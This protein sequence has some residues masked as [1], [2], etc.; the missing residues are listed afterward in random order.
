ME[1]PNS[2]KEANVQREVYLGGESNKAFA[3]LK[4]YLGSPQLL[5]R[6]ESGET[7]QLYLAISDVAVSSMLIKESSP[8]S[9]IQQE[10]EGTDPQGFEWSMHVDGALND[11]GAGAGVLITGPQ[12]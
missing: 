12:G 11:K 5:S 1:P 3:E 9:P 7:L 2:Y 10:E 6:P 8:S 4:E